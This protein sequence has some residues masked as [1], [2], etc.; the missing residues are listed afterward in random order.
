LAPVAAQFLADG[1]LA[2]ANRLS[3]GILG[4]SGLCHGGYHFTFLT[5][6]AGAFVIHSQFVVKPD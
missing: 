3:D 6:E 4:L 5:A 1:S 2:T